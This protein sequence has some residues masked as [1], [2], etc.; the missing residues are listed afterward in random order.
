[1][2]CPKCGAITEVRQKRGPFRDRRCVNPACIFGFTT[3]ENL[4]TQNEH[5]RINAKALARRCEEG[6]YS[7]AELQ[8][9]AAAG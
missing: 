1:M 4:A 3:C 9:A 7:P 2:R 5:Q 6:V 8:K